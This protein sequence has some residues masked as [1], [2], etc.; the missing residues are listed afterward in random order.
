MGTIQNI[1]GVQ[2]SLSPGYVSLAQNKYLIEAFQK[3]YPGELEQVARTIDSEFANALMAIRVEPRFSE[4]K[5]MLASLEQGMHTDE[6][7][8]TFAHVLRRAEKAFDETVGKGFQDI[9][10]ENKV[11]LQKVTTIKK[12]ETVVQRDKLEEIYQAERKKLSNHYAANF[13]MPGE[14][15]V[16]GTKASKGAPSAKED[17]SK[18]IINTGAK[19]ED[20]VA[21]ARPKSIPLKFAG[22]KRKSWM[23]ENLRWPYSLLKSEGKDSEIKRD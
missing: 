6:G 15:M 12:D 20:K 22:L 8:E 5:K 10:F 11:M 23:L 13:F 18:D 21:L 7:K 14:V 3:N 9:I 1:S 19:E 2:T 4:Q 17:T 16:D